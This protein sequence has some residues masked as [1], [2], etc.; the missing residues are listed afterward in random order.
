MKTFFKNFFLA[1]TLISLMASFLIDSF[2]LQYDD[3]AIGGITVVVMFVFGFIR[4]IVRELLSILSDGGIQHW[5]ILI[6]IGLSIL[7]AIIFDQVLN[8][9]RKLIKSK[10]ATS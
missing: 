6:E 10:K 2:E 7:I 4:Q 3:G 1:L 9:A 8:R 5:G